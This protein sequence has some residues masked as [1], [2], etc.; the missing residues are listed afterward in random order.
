MCVVLRGERI[1]PVARP[2]VAAT[3]TPVPRS[4]RAISPQIAPD[5]PVIQASLPGKLLRH[6]HLLG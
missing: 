2:R 6:V 5:A 4:R 1:E 3:V